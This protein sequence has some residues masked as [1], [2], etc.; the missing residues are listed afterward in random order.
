MYEYKANVVRV[1]DGDTIIVNIDLGFDSWKFNQR[2]RLLGINAP[3]LK[4]ITKAN[5]LKSK[6]FL[7]SLFVDVN[8]SVVLHTAKDSTDKYGR[9]LADVF[10]SYI[11]QSINEYLVACGMAVKATYK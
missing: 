4:G 6:E 2:I 5:G 3:E 7:E 9:Y 8:G 1:I 10:V 11:S